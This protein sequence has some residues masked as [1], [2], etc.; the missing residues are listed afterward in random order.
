MTAYV[1]GQFA[2]REEVAREAVRQGRS[3]ELGR[4]GGQEDV[5]V[6]PSA[7]KTISEAAF[8]DAGSLVSEINQALRFALRNRLSAGPGIHGSPEDLA[9]EVGLVFDRFL[10]VVEFSVPGQ[11]IPGRTWG[12]RRQ[13]RVSDRGAFD[14]W[15]A[16]KEAGLIR[17]REERAAAKEVTDRTVIRQHRLALE[18]GWGKW[19]NEGVRERTR[20]DKNVVGLFYTALRDGRTCP[21]CRSYDGIMRPK[22]DP[23]WDQITPP[24]HFGCGLRCR[25]VPITRFEEWSPTAQGRIPKVQP[26]EGFGGTRKQPKAGPAMEGRVRAIEQ[27]IKGVETEADARRV[28]S[29]I[30]RLGGFTRERGNLQDR[31]VRQL[32]RVGL[33]WP[34]NRGRAG[35]VAELQVRR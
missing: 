15:R 3:V 17:R 34:E 9:A 32:R 11:R 19:F 16:E 20:A 25:V 12:G 28:M 33:E 4:L 14:R 27:R 5:V 2:T 7:L 31:L 22:G 10:P 24:N 35:S 13:M 30:D 8:V 1:H 23:I 21:I 26:D 18:T 29:D 6:P